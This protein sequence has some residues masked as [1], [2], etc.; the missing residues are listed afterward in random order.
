MSRSIDQILDSAKLAERTLA[1]YLG[2]DRDL[3]ARYHQLRVDLVDAADKPP[4]SLAA[5]SPAKSI[6]DEMAAIEATMAEDTVVFTL[7]ALRRKAWRELREAHP[8]RKDPAT[9]ETHQRDA[10]LGANIDTLPEAVVRASIIAPEL[11]PEQMD[12]LLDEDDGPLDE[13]LFE[14]LWVACY[15]LNRG[16]VDVP[17]TSPNSPP[18][19]TS[20]PG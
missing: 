10:L 2:G 5:G 11:T 16:V 7:R 4:T 14:Q 20:A 15:G 19:P 18:T 8:P 3:S 9:G 13:A 1:L 17:F 12:R 6:R